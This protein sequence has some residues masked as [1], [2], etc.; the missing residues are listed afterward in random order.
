MKSNK[1]KAAKKKTKAKKAR[2]LL[3]K[4]AENNTEDLK[5]DENV[6]DEDEDLE[7]S[8]ETVCSICNPYGEITWWKEI[9]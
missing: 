1:E 5:N 3:M 8:N 2:K 7:N 4:G 9:G 6:N